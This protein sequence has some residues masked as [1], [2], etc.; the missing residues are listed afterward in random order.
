MQGIRKCHD[1]LQIQLRFERDGEEVCY[2]GARPETKVTRYRKV[3][4]A[5]PENLDWNQL[6]SLF[7]HFEATAEHFAWGNMTTFIIY[8]DINEVSIHWETGSNQVSLDEFIAHAKNTWALKHSENKEWTDD[9]GS[10]IHAR[11]FGDATALT[12]EDTVHIQLDSGGP[13]FLPRQIKDL[14]KP[15]I[16]RPK[17]PPPLLEASYVFAPYVPQPEPEPESDRP[18]V[19]EID[20]TCSR[21][22]I[23]YT[24]AARYSSPLQYE[25]KCQACGEIGYIEGKGI[26]E[27]AK[28]GK[29]IHLSWG[30]DDIQNY[31]IMGHVT[32]EFITVAITPARYYNDSIEEPECQFPDLTDPATIGA[33]R[34]QDA[35][36]RAGTLQPEGRLTK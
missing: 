15:R 21:T 17:S 5:T 1:I 20:H 14:I 23:R 12:P 13:E 18:P 9:S 24:G 7:S 11:S 2:M 6:A 22:E 25:W 30:D 27:Q 8:E 4:T 3:T 36:E 31:N 19:I 26:M 33:L 35:R 29:F 16:V 34:V 32:D 10:F 28:P